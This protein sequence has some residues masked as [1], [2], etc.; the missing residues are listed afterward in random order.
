LSAAA[1]D[2]EDVLT[3]SHPG[4]AAFVCPMCIIGPAGSCESQA[5][6][7]LHD[8]LTLC[9]PKSTCECHETIVRYVS[10]IR[11]TVAQPSV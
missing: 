8:M 4:G 7:I 2:S 9:S 6:L 11:G 10:Q 3:H 1:T 5:A